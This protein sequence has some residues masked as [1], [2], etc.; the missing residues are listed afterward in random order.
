MISAI[1]WRQLWSL[2]E[3]ETKA[4]LVRGVSRYSGDDRNILS[5][6]ILVHWSRSSM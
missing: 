3:P 1:L 4:S 5:E 2:S 6:I